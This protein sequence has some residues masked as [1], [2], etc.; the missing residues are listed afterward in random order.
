MLAL[1]NGEYRLY[2][3]DNLQ[4]TA[5]DMPNDGIKANAYGSRHAFED[6]P[7]GLTL[8]WFEY[9][10]YQSLIRVHG[11]DSGQRWDYY[12]RY[13][14][15]IFALELK[16]GGNDHIWHTY[17]GKREIANEEFLGR[18]CDLGY[19]KLVPCSH[20]YEN[21]EDACNDRDR[22]ANSREVLDDFVSGKIDALYSVEGV[23]DIRRS[24]CYEKL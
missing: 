1:K 22:I 8:Y 18:L 13:E 21:M 3:F 17:D 7:E 9:V 10:P 11:G 4:I 14:N 5:I 2:T 19:E 6:Y 16:A 24:F 12:L 20:L 15:G 23:T